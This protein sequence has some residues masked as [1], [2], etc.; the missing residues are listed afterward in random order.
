MRRTITKHAF[1]VIA[2][3]AAFMAVLLSPIPQASADEGSRDM[4]RLY[5]PNSGE[6]FYTADSNERDHLTGVGWVYEGIGWRAPV[7]SSVPVYRL[8]NSNA[9]D[10]SR[11]V[12]DMK[13]SVGIPPILIEAIRCTAS[14]IR[15]P[16]P[17]LITTR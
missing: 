7:Q 15:M 1:V 10:H 5:N 8:Y 14:T 12:G 4:Y 13:V 6:H 17:V 3:M 2:V 16:K 11:K 9:G